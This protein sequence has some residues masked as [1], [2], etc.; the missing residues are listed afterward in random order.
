MGL[1]SRFSNARGTQQ[2]SPTEQI[3]QAILAKTG[4]LTVGKPSRRFDDLELGLGLATALRWFGHM[5]CIERDVPSSV[6]QFRNNHS[7][8]CLVAL[9]LAFIEAGQD[10]NFV[11]ALR[12]ARPNIDVYRE[13]A[14]LTKRATSD[15]QITFLVNAT[16][17]TTRHFVEALLA[18]EASAVVHI[19]DKLSPSEQVAT[20]SRWIN[21]TLGTSDCDA[22][23]PASTV[24]SLLGQRWTFDLGIWNEFCDSI[25]GFSTIADYNLDTLSEDL[26]RHLRSTGKMSAEEELR[27]RSRGKIMQM[28]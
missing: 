20:A 28:R 5:K 14:V 17:Y 6:A 15:E 21:S 3:K 18:G 23:L 12:R 22:F 16:A 26:V 19:L 7:N 4:H 9:A 27:L 2:P 24:N 11:A 1:F 25:G 8:T 10:Q 13:V